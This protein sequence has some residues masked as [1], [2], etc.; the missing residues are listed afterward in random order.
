M[1]FGGVSYLNARP[2]L[3]GLRPLVLDAPA[4]LTERYRR[5]ELDV[6]LLPVAFGEA[7]GLPRV[8]DLGIAAE[9]PVDSVLLFHTKPPASIRRVVLDP[10]SRTSQALALLHLRVQ[11]GVVPEVVEQGGDAE[12]VIGDRALARGRGDEARIDLAE[13]WSERTG[14]P[15]VFAA[16]YGDSAAAGALAAAFARGARKRRAYAKAASRALE[17]PAP[18]LERYLEERVRYRI[19]PREREGLA[20]FLAEARRYGLL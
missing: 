2:L 18:Y 14:L 17:L 20:R 5:G 9:G 11:Y 8:G 7:L 1:R 13:V 16:W 4:R 10:E 19:G 15:F 12:L 3:E 6:A